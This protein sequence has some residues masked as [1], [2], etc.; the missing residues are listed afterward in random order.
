MAIVSDQH[1]V[2]ISL[3]FENGKCFGTT[4]HRHFIN[5]QK[6]KVFPHYVS[7]TF[8]RLVKMETISASRFRGD[9][10]RCYDVPRYINITPQFWYKSTVFSSR[11]TVVILR[12]ELDEINSPTHLQK[13]L[14]FL[15]L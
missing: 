14:P 4:I 1:F 8:H 15:T 11:P 5:F 12:S 7:S 6:W 10:Q 2:A 3:T 9:F 13:C